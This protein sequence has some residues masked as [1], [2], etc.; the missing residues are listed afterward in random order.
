MNFYLHV[1]NIFKSAYLQEYYKKKNAN[2][3]FNSIIY[4]MPS[5][6]WATRHFEKMFTMDIT[7]PSQSYFA[8]LTPPVR[9]VSKTQ[10]SPFLAKIA[11]LNYNLKTH[12]KVSGKT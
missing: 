6:R 5:H 9:Q 8:E 1:H 11:R 4:V 7:H 10:F 2:C 12:Q 3:N